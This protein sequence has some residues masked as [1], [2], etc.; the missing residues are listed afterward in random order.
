MKNIF[1]KFDPQKNGF[2]TEDDFL[3]FYQISCTQKPETVWQN[4]KAHL[5]KNNLKKIDDVEEKDVDVESLPRFIIA[6]DYEFFNS[7]FGFLDV[8]EETTTISWDL[9]NRLPTSPAIF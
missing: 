8:G 4:L 9:I 7:I 1:R 6:S 5:Y 3:K 2:I